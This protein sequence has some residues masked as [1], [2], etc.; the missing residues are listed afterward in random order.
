[1]TLHDIAEINPKTDVRHLRDDDLVSFIPMSD[2]TDDGRWLG[3]DTRTLRSVR[4]GYTAF[5]EGDVLFAKITPCMENGKGARVKRLRNG[6]GFGSTEYHVLRARQESDAD[7]VYQWTKFRELRGNA[8]NAMTGSAG[9]QRVPSAYIAQYPITEHGADER[10]KI[11]EVLS[12]LDDAIEQTETLLAKQQRIK[13]GLMHDLLTR[14]LDAQGR[15]RDPSTH[16]F[17]K[18]PLGLIPEEWDEGN[19][20]TKATLHNNLRKPLSSA[21]RERMQG[22]YP[23]HGPTGVFD[24]INEFRLE[25]RFVLIGEDG[26]HFLK[27]ATHEMTQLVEGRFNVNNHAHVMTGRNGCTTDWLHHYFRHRD[28]TYFLTRQ[29]A[30]RYKLNKA[31]LLSLP[32]PVPSPD[33]QDRIAL[34]LVAEDRFIQKLRDQLTKLRRLKT[35]LMHDLLTGERS[36]TPLLTTSPS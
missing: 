2:L 9:Q 19:I 6:I 22:I 26:D 13:T 32:L 29:G 11:A 20:E 30:G 24:H 27:F 23:Y 7:F 18:S 15:L 1:M 14:G 28:L 35:G 3:D 5:A 4:H 25:G 16:R 10:S 33:E 17:K 36:V 12:K 21:V 8:A 34:R 31:T